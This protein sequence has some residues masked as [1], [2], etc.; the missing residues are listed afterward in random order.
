[1]KRKRTIRIC[2]S[3]WKFEAKTEKVGTGSFCL[4]HGSGPSRI[5]IGTK[6]RT[7]RDI[8][9]TVLH[10]VMESILVVDGKRWAESHTNAIFCFNHWYLQEFDAKVLDALISIGMVDPN[11]KV[12]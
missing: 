1:M 7:K 6:G 12:I 9:E 3:E 4:D 5:R 8:L 10:E 11:K 2:S